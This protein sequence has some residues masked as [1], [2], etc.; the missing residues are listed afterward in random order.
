[1]VDKLIIYPLLDLNKFINRIILGEIKGKGYPCTPIKDSDP[2][3]MAE[4][5]GFK[6][7]EIDQQLFRPFYNTCSAFLLEKVK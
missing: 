7:I 5:A 2:I 6:V 3:A 1:M 4:D